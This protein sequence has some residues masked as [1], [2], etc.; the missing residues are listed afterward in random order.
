MAGTLPEVELPDGAPVI[1]L[2]G[3][4]RADIRAVEDCPKELQPLAE[5]DITKRCG[6]ENS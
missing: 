4:S 3:V 6:L 1:Y 5:R 2:P